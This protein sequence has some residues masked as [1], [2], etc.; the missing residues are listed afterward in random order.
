M[1]LTL[2]IISVLV[3]LLI[4]AAL[5]LWA[6]R[7]AAYFYRRASVELTKHDFKSAT[8]DYSKAIK[9]KPDYVEAFI[10]RGSAE[11]AE[12]TWDAALANYSK[13]AQLK[14]DLLPAPDFVKRP[15][16]VLTNDV[17]RQ[18]LAFLESKDYDKLDELAARLRSSKEYFPDGVWK[19]ACVYDGITPSDRATDEDWDARLL[20]IGRWAETRPDSITAHIA[21]AEV[22]VAYAWKA[23]GTGGSG[24]VSNEGWRV[25]RQRLIEAANFLKKAKSLKE[26]CPHYW[27]VLLRDALG[28]QA[29]RTQFNAI[30][31]EAIKSEPNCAS[32]YYRRAVYFLTQWYG[33]EGEW[34]GDLA[35]SA[36]KIGGEKGDLLYAQVIWN[37][38]E[39]YGLNPFWDDAQAWTRVDKGFAVIEKKFPESLPAKIERAQLAILGNHARAAVFYNSGLSKQ[40]NG[41]FAGA[42][43]DFTKAIEIKHDYERAYRARG[44]LNEAKGD[45]DGAMADYTK[46][47]EISPDNVSALNSRALLKRRKGDLS[48]AMADFNK[49]IELKPDVSMLYILYT[50]RGNLKLAAGDKAGAAAD[51]DRATKLV[52]QQPGKIQQ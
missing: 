39:R 31:D 22:L 17:A 44:P 16:V 9:L 35:K 24:T 50:G 47:I 14:P 6:Q 19:L 26:Q 33:K 43:A 38:H 15:D 8:A 4:V 40:R 46:A 28:L 52:S 49:A 30:F 25:F 18:A 37:M 11:Y 27:R 36:D 45:L 1:K 23:R 21:R 34:H 29:G 51:H 7:D 42:I 5:L 2:K 48:G 20:A 13:A 32:F 10:G 41:D 3:A 12:E